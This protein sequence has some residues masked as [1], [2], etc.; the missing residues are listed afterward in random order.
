[1][2]GDRSPGAVRGR[3]GEGRAGH[4][5]RCGCRR[6]GR[7]RG[8]GLRRAAGRGSRCPGEGSGGSAPPAQRRRPEV[9]GRGTGGPGGKR[10]RTAAGSARPSCPLAISSRET[11]RSDSAGSRPGRGGAST[12]YSTNG[13]A[14]G[15]VCAGWTLHPPAPGSAACGRDR[16]GAPGTPRTLQ[17]PL[18][19]RARPRPFRSSWEPP[20]SGTAGHPGVSRTP[21]GNL[22]TPLRRTSPGQPP[23]PWAAPPDPHYL[24][25]PPHPGSSGP[26]PLKRPPPG[27][28]PSCKASPE[29]TSSLQGAWA[30]VSGIPPGPPNVPVGLGCMWGAGGGGTVGPH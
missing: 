22:G 8:V 25:Q 24:A 20:G 19:S 14:G 2:G 26:H 21:L 12:S 13:T 3:A 28:P 7:G 9:T 23:S 18:P 10:K 5:G 27:G 15:G 17:G 4:G 6:C 1:M 16:P 29:S 11:A 30:A